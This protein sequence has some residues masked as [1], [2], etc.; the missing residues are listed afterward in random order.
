MMK[1]IHF[2]KGFTLIELMVV[3]V[4]LGILA[5]VVVPQFAGFTNTTKLGAAKTELNTNFPRALLLAMARKTDRCASVVK[6]D[7]LADGVS[8]PNLNVYNLVWTVTGSATNSVSI[9]YPTVSTADATDL[10]ANLIAEGLG[11]QA[12][13]SAVAA[14][15]VNVNITFNCI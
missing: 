11:G 10:A 7:L 8:F 9:R 3:V 13:M 4:I 5:S 2:S 12:L 6:A 15:G 1:K 14:S